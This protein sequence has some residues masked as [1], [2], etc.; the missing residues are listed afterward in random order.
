VGIDFD[1]LKTGDTSVDPGAARASR[2]FMTVEPQR[3]GGANPGHVGGTNRIRIHREIQKIRWP[4]QPRTDRLQ[5]LPAAAAQRFR[6]CQDIA[7]LPAEFPMLPTR[8]LG[9]NSETGITARL[10]LLIRELHHLPERRATGSLAIHY[11]PHIQ[12]SV[13]VD[14]FR[15]ETSAA[16]AEIVAEG[17]FVA[18]PEHHG[19]GPRCE[20]GA[21]HNCQVFLRLFQVWA[22]PDVAQING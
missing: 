16:I 17:C 2:K 11:G 4:E 15:I 13:Q 6:G 12:V 7:P 20:D 18:A 9:L 8:G 3:I 1:Y 14:D 10:E 5:V 21:H 19:D 22:N